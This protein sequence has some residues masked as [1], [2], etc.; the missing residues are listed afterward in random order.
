MMR[1]AV[2]AVI[3][4]LVLGFTEAVVKP[5][6]K[7]WMQRRLLSAAPAVLKQL[8]A[9]LP[10]LLLSTDAEGI[11]LFTRETLKQVTGESW[12]DVNIDPLFELFDIRKAAGKALEHIDD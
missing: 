9:R 2:D 4:F 8:D 5:F 11:E 7:R 6:A 3:A 12:D 1:S 10:A